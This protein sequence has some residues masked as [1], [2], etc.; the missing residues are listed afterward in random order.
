MY[1]CL[2]PY[3]FI[4]RGSMLS[5]DVNCLILN[6]EENILYAGCGD[7]AVAVYSFNLECGDVIHKYQGHNDFIHSFDKL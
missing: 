7:N 1:Y 6:K 5:I 2:K 3:I 4:F